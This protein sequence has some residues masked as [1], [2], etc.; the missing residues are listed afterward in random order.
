MF[1]EEVVGGEDHTRG[2]DAAL[3]T[4]GGEE[5]LLNGME[6]G[7]AAEAFDGEDGGGV[8]LEEGDEAGVDEVAV[9]EDGAGAALAFAAAL[10]GAGE[11]EVLAEN[12]KETFKGWGGDGA[13]LA[14]DRAGDGR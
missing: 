1:L 2:A 5:A 9:E 4:A 12:V 8:N 7:W 14:V 6:V 10:F 3:R 11:V 13:R